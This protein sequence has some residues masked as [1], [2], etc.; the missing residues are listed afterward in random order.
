MMNTNNLNIDDLIKSRLSEQNATSSFFIQVGAGAGDRDSRANYRDGFT[1]IIKRARLSDS[2]RILLVEPNPFNLDKLRES[3]NEF[4]NI[5]IFQL[6]IVPKSF[7]GQVLRFFFTELDGPH[8]QVA[9]FNSHHVL[10]H[11][12]ELKES[13]LQVIGVDTLDL[14]TFTDQTTQGEEI[15]LLALDIEGID[16]EVLLDTDFSTMN[17]YLLS[18]E[19][20]HLGAREAEVITHLINCGFEY[21]GSGVDHNGFDVLWKKI[22]I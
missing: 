19:R 17:V 7:S 1:E 4:S 2:H 8:Y 5:E 10:K 12:L 20:L 11:Y 16:A 13:D 18:F 6:G 15:V 3:W 14:K 22:S 21:V 9:S